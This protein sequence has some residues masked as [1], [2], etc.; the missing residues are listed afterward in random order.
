MVLLP[1]L[2]MQKPLNEKTRKAKSFL[3]IATIALLIYTYATA[4]GLTLQWRGV[5]NT[6]AADHAVTQTVSNPTPTPTSYP[7]PTS[8]PTNTTSIPTPTEKLSQSHIPEQNNQEKQNTPLPG[9]ISPIPL[10]QI[11]GIDVNVQIQLPL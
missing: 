1:F 10:P 3:I 8:S 6:Q 2:K 5:K 4:H 9:V 7:T 11:T